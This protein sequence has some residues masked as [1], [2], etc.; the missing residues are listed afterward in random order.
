MSLTEVLLLGILIMQVIRF[1]YGASSSGRYMKY[2]DA[3]AHRLTKY[4]G[5]KTKTVTCS[6]GN[7]LTKE[8]R[9]V[10][11]NSG[12][13]IKCLI[14]VVKELISLS[15]G[16]QRRSRDAM[17]LAVVKIRAFKERYG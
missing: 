6:S 14:K 10:K 8:Y 2:Y 1:H 11:I 7:Q 9:Y 3:V 15:Q 5:Q 13:K 12:R 4:L 17:R 16:I